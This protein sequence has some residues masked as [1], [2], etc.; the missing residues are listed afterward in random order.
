MLDEISK[1]VKPIGKLILSG[2]LEADEK[3]IK[4]KYEQLGFELV[5][6]NQMDEWIEL[7]FKK[8]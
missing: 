1:R 4:E 8:R 2:L 5:N 3:D 6:K 7:V